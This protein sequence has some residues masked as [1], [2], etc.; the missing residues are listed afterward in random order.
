MNGD[1]RPRE[2]TPVE[3]AQALLLAVGSAAAVGAVIF[4]LAKT[5]MGRERIRIEPPELGRPRAPT[6]ETGRLRSGSP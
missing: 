1:W 4:W 2:T 3:D 6:N 5:L